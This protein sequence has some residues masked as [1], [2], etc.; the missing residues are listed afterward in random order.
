MKI[1]NYHTHSMELERNYNNYLLRYF[2][3]LLV[4]LNKIKVLNKAAI[5]EKISI[6]QKDNL[7]A[8]VTYNLNYVKKIKDY[9]NEVIKPRGE[10]KAEKRGDIKTYADSNTEMSDI[11]TEYI[12]Q[13]FIELSIL[14]KSYSYSDQQSTEFIQDVANTVSN[15]VELLAVMSTINNLREFVFDNADSRGFTEY[16]W[17]TQRDNKVRPTHANNEGQ[18]FSLSTPTPITGFPGH[19]YNCRCYAV[20]FR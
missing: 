17:R 6:W 8:L 13:K 10:T 5:N 12:R 4:D 20:A 9:A 11:T 18:W 15:R 1:V 2:G 16:Q 19:D 14:E 7:D 3:T